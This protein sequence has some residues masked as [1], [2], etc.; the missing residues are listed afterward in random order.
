MNEC[1]REL[2]ETLK[3]EVRWDSITRKIYSVDASIF[4]VEPLGVVLPETQEELILTLQIA[5]KHHVPVIARGAATGITGSCLGRGLII[6]ISKYLNQIIEI[7]IEEEYAICEPGVVQDRLNEAL[8]PFG[9]R[10]GPDT[11]TGNRATIGGMMANNSAGARSLRYGRMV[12]HVEMIELALAN[13]ELLTF[14][15]LS[16]AQWADKMAQLDREG[17]IYRDVDAIRQYYAPAILQHFPNIPRRVSGYNLDQLLGNYPLNLSKLIV[18]SEG[19]LGIATRIKVKIAKKPKHTALSIIHVEDMI[20]GLTHIGAM[21]KHSP[22]ALEMIDDKILS[23]GRQSPAVKHKMEW[24]KGYPQAVFVAEFDGNTSTEVQEKQARFKCEMQ[25]LNLG[26]AYVELSDPL[27][28]SYV[29]EVRKAGLG[30]LLSKRSYSR[31]IAFIEDISIAPDK[32][33]AFLQHFTR[34]LKQMG[35]EAGIYG[36]IGSGCM[37]IRPYI[38]LRDPSE[39]SIMH[40]IMDEV[41]SMVLEYQ[42]AMSGEHGDGL[43]RSWLNEKMFGPEVYAAFKKV[44]YAFDPQQ[45][46]NPGKVVDG[47]PPSHD[48]RL[49]PSTPNMSIPT[50]LD[51]G[52][53]GG[54]ELAADLCNGNGQCRKA[55]NVMCPSF[56]ASNDEYHTTRARA[57]TLRS[58]IH[59]KLPKE[60][61]TGQGLFD[62]LDLCIECKGCKR[63]CPSQV[64]MA[65]MKAEFLYQYQEKHGYTLRSRIFGHI[66]AFN[67]AVTPFA[68]L[69][70]GILSSK[71]GKWLLARFGIAPQRAF[72]RLTTER[73]STWFKKQTQTH[74][75]KR[76]ALFNDTYTEFNHPEIG[77]ATFK[78]LAALGYEITLINDLCCGRPLIS[79]GLLKQ[80]KANAMEVV[81]KLHILAQQELPIIVLEP[82]CASALR[83]DFI[84]LVGKDLSMAPKLEAVSK[85]VT[86]LDEF[87]QTKLVDGILPLSFKA[88]RQQVLV[89]THCHQ[90]ALVGSQAS[91]DVLRG[92]AA[93]DVH[94]ISS[95]CCGVAG[96]FGYEKEHYD[97]SMQIGELHLLPAVRQA[98]ADT[99]IIASG[100]S[101]RSQ[102]THG[103]KRRPMHLAEAIAK[104]L[105]LKLEK[106]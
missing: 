98:H 28:M 37:H 91:L 103:T 74:S 81:D 66:H 2:K 21:L 61:F 22:L 50:F 35:K 10:L 60:E 101:C 6:D 76:I 85:A 92:I 73:F 24:L 65:K 26:Y 5:A 14:S 104:Q 8:S 72:P 106:F 39:L 63:E 71:P 69:V 33:A 105:K 55:E 95:G 25:A 86:S 1:F 19:T 102:I 7:N 62:V 59:G 79:K 75:S 93:F 32:L 68:S 30:L 64:D 13:G 67:K 87:L 34:Y 99:I 11:S 43:I 88:A 20:Q 90:K 57:Q 77:Q 38:D 58:I 48:L 42:G 100:V 97:F 41:S 84:G 49:S 82:S 56:Q 3:S 52:R 18:G 44:K 46:M 54:F 9:Y 96:S 47:P 12:D 94:E 31:A 70:N 15:P 51:F 40:K 80:A 36:H 16:E 83:D 4:E 78:V 53:E 89:H 23:M 45:L 27:Q 29:W 17:T